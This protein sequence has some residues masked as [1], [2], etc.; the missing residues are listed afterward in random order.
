[1]DVSLLECL[2]WLIAGIFR[3]TKALLTSSIFILLHSLNEFKSNLF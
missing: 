3:E 1:M 2:K